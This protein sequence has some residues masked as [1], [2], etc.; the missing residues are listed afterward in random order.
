MLWQSCFQDWNAHNIAALK[1]V[2]DLLSKN[3]QE[4]LSLFELPRRARLKERFCLVGIF[5]L[6]RQTGG[7]TFSLFMVTLFK[8]I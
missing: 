7:R 5:G 2:R 4:I 8:Q 1:D 3:Y 6:Y